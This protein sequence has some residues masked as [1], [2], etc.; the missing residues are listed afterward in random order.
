M[1]V[2]LGSQCAAWLIQE[3]CIVLDPM[4]T[5][6]DGFFWSFTGTLVRQVVSAFFVRTAIHSTAGTLVV[7][8][9][10]ALLGD[11]I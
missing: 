8:H 7:W 9:T 6:A 3:L 2:V 5:V 11:F 4:A 10:S 1:L